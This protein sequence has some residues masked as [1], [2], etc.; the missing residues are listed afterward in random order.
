MKLWR[1]LEAGGVIFLEGNGEGPGVH[2]KRR[3]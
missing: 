1:T 2:L 3:S